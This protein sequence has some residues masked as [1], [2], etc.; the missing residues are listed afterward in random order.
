MTKNFKTMVVEIDYQDG[1]V[2]GLAIKQVRVNGK[3]VEVDPQYM[4]DNRLWTLLQDTEN[5][6]QVTLEASWY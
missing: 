6:A 4:G 5:D 2:N 1:P 3:V